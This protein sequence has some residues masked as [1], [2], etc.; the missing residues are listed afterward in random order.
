MI[1]D[2]TILHRAILAAEAATHG[3]TI[4]CARKAELAQE[5]D[6]EEKTI[7]VQRILP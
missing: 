7:R 5:L 4:T 6:V 2:S 3:G 1:S